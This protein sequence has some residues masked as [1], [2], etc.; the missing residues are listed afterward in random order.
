[1][2]TSF[3]NDN[4]SRKGNPESFLVKVTFFLVRRF[5]MKFPSSV[6][7]TFHPCRTS[8]E[9]LSSRLIGRSL[10]KIA[11][12]LDAIEF[13]FNT[14]QKPSMPPPTPLMFTLFSE[15]VSKS[16]LTADK[17]YLLPLSTIAPSCAN[18]SCFNDSSQSTSTS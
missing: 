5:F 13:R 16:V 2:F 9:V 17:M 1:M 14:P 7:N 4:V 15:I 12:I 8:S 10:A 3:I 11:G 18:W 6:N